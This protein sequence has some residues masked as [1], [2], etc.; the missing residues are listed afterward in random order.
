M[1]L[2]L[3]LTT[4][5]SSSA[6]PPP[7]L[8]LSP[9]RPSPDGTWQVVV[10]PE[11]RAPLPAE[12]AARIEVLTTAELGPDVSRWLALPGPRRL[13]NDALHVEHPGPGHAQQFFAARESGLPP[14]VTVSNA[15]A[16]RAAVAAAQPGSRIQL[17]P[18][19]YPGGFTFA[20]LHGATDL[21]IVIAAA[22]P[23]R[24]PHI[25]G[26]ANGI[27]LTD[28]AFVELHDLEFSGATGNGLNLDDGGTFD[29]PAHD[30]VL[31]G[32]RVIDVGPQGNHDG[33]KLSGVIRFRVEGCTV[34]RWGTG[35]SAIDM[36]GC[37]QGLIVS[38]LFRHTAA[39]AESGSGVQAKG[40]SRDVVI[41]RNRFENAG[42]RAVNLGGST[43]LEFFRPPLESGADHWEAK[44][45][46]VE[47]NT[48][49]G[50][51]APLAFV[52]VDG[53]VVRFNTF[54]RPQRWLMRILQE[55]TVTGFVPCRNGRFSD[56]LIAFHSTQWSAGGVN[57]G[58]NTAPATFRFTRNAWYCL[59]AP[60]RSRPSLPTTET[61]GIYGADPQFLD[62]EG[63]DFRLRP[64]SPTRHVGAD[65][66]PSP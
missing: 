8:R 12:R 38:N 3:S 15:S 61:A 11:D 19:T 34:E 31:R 63:G 48:F 64:G 7:G 65:A 16:F 60:A 30:L 56:N 4:S 5:T 41:R 49:L 42:S 6:A 25:E 32:L 57:I 62:A 45:L 24:P 1:V 14:S 46:T 54:Y 50:S 66:L 43:G 18:G 21:P 53:A 29:T 28:A 22:D 51:A 23:S 59:D 26:G 47:G 36:V 52:G 33:I 20:N 39:A 55:T 37:H 9:P 44:D 10:A 2:G 35:G 40:G 13:T 27:Q 58:P 17:A